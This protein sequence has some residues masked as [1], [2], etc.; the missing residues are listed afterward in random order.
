MQDLVDRVD[1][2]RT[3][4]GRRSADAQTTGSRAGRRAREQAPRPTQRPELPPRAETPRADS[5]PIKRAESPADRIA[6]TALPTGTTRGARKPAAPRRAADPAGDPVTDILPAVTDTAA[7]A[8]RAKPVKTAPTAPPRRPGAGERRGKQARM[9]GR[10]TLTVF[11]VLTLVVTGGGWSYLQATNNSFTQVSALD[12]STEDVLDG[13]MQ[14]GDENYLIVGTDSRAG[15]NADVGAGTIDD[16]EGARAD[17]VML[18]H[19]PQDRSRVV[20]V[21]FPRDLDVTRPQ[22]AQFDNAANKYE[23]QK[24][25]GAVG[26]KLNAVYAFGGPRCLVDVIRKMSGLNI[27]HFIGIDFAGFQ[28]MVDHI[29][30]VEVCSTKPIIDGVLGTVLES[31]GKQRIN[32]E[33]ALNYVRARHVIGDE[34]SD[35]DRIHR[36][37]TF[38]AALL[39]GALSSQVLLDPAKLQGFVNAFSQ[40]TFVDGVEAK[41]LI[42]LG[43]SLQKVNAG[44]VTFITAPTAGTTDYGNEIPRESDIKSI[45]RAII[46][47]QPLPGEQTAPPVTSSS[48]STP[49]P[50]TPAPTMY[51]VS[52][53]TVSLQVNN[54]SMTAGIARQ[55]AN[56]LSTQGFGIYSVGNDPAGSDTTKVRYSE[57]NEAAAATVA[58]AIP[59]ATLERNDDLYGIVEVVI[60]AD[61]SGQIRTPTD[62]G[63]ELPPI[64]EG[65]PVTAAPVALPSDLEHMN[66]ADTSCD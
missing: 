4:R 6:T 34:R 17:T 59:G 3:R 19:I 8:K 51:A 62:V 58:S 52:P 53:G 21:S 54:A 47:N 38:L 37:Q 60:G 15:A 1:S 18:V 46:D 12:G 27:G 24:S 43:R 45:F 66:A 36:Q 64:T 57:G 5:A 7:P 22:C 10:I 49:T 13:S 16:A 41:D 55:T 48:S 50:A 42:L 61:F 63:S 25:P 14:L 40:H 11:A 29:D 28:A 65:K 23:S 30:G 39:R 2:E 9:A 31:S 56:K 26:D 44:A 33:T 20:V 32:G 35:Y